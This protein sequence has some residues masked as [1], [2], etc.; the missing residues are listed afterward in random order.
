MAENINGWAIE[1]RPNSFAERFAY[2]AVALTAEGYLAARKGFQTK[3]A[4]IAFAKA[5]QAPAV[6]NPDMIDPL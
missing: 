4:A 5:T 6:R 1:K 2:E 3:K